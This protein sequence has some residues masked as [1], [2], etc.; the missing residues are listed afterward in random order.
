MNRTDNALRKKEY[1]RRG[2]ISVAGLLAVL[3]L[4]SCGIPNMKNTGEGTEGK[5]IGEW[6]GESSEGE[7]IVMDIWNDDDG[8]LHAEISRADNDNEVVFWSFS[9]EAKG[10]SFSYT[11]GERMQVVYNAAGEAEEE[12][13]YSDGSGS[14]ERSEEVLLWHDRKEGIGDGVTFSYVGEY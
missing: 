14:V 11:D 2:F 12:V 6:Q 3:F 13:V 10:N 9:G 7:P 1:F 5:F 8:V 4:V